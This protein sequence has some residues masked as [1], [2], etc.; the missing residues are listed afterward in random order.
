MGRSLEKLTFG[1][2]EILGIL[3]EAI[4][5]MLAAPWVGNTVVV[6]VAGPAALVAAFL[7]QRLS[8]EEKLPRRFVA[9]ARARR[10]Q[11]PVNL[12]SGAEG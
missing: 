5:A 2:F 4:V 3:N 6:V 9:M 11:S 8:G 1:S 7:R 12:Q 10:G